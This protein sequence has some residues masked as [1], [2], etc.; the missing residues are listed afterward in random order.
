MSFH[1][2]F[3]F[4][5]VVYIKCISRIVFLSI[6]FCSYQ[7]DFLQKFETLL[8]PCVLQ[9]LYCFRVS[10][11]FNSILFI[12]TTIW[13]LNYGRM[14]SIGDSERGNKGYKL[15]DKKACSLGPTEFCQG[16]FRTGQLPQV[17]VSSNLL[18]VTLLCQHHLSF[19]F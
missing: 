16:Q 11:V 12:T 3:G 4:F 8:G 19:D 9:R 14:Y 1:K 10:A 13:L 7:G 15:S 18:Q 6:K 5:P 2:W 17:P